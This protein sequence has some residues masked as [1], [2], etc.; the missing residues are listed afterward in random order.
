MAAGFTGDEIKGFTDRE[1]DSKVKR[2]SMRLAFGTRD[3]V[4]MIRNI[5]LR[6]LIIFHIGV[7]RERVAAFHATRFPFAIRLH[8]AAVDRKGAGFAN[9]TVDGAES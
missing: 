2:H 7:N 8:A 4:Q 9:R 3:A 1:D 6:S 5:G